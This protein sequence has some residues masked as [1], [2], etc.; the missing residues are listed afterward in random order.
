MTRDDV[1]PGDE[2]KNG[3]TDRWGK[4]VAIDADAVTG[5]V[6]RLRVRRRI[7]PR[8]WQHEPTWWDARSITMVEAGGG[9]R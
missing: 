8:Q 4:V 3:R 7:G 5:N 6:L 2:V 9:G 1:K